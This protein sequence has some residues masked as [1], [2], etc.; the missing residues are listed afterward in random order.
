MKY[1]NSGTVRP[2]EIN[3]LLIDTS[4][5]MELRGETMTVTFTD[6]EPSVPRHGTYRRHDTS[7]GAADTH[8]V[9][10]YTDAALYFTGEQPVTIGVPDDG[11]PALMARMIDLLVRKRLR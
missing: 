4:G 11:E 1:D 5:S 3:R 10:M 2:G 9:E 8:D 6:G 7:Q